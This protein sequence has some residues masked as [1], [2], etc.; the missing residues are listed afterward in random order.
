MLIGVLGGTF[1][2]PH[3]GHTALAQAAQS[4]LGVDLVLWVVAEPWQKT[5]QTPGPIRAHL[6]EL[7]IDGHSGWQVSYAD[8]ERGAP[9]YSIDTIS[10]LR[11]AWPEAGFV[12]LLGADA[13]AGLASW[14]AAER[15][16]AEVRFAAARRDG[17]A[18][19]VP[20]GFA[21]QLLDA[22]IPS[23]S[24]TEVR[25]LVASGESV[26]GPVEPRVAQYIAEVGLYL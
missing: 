24:S 18:P 13:V 10:D 20:A 15:V 19:A 6:C 22:E 3:I 8:L 5:A 12:W 16:A 23:V 4:E 7:A 14:H 26:E 9:T 1:D 21:V 17:Q 2:P 25:R 11:A